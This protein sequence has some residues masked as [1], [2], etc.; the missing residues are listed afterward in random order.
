ML[1][2]VIEHPLKL[3]MIGTEAPHMTQIGGG[4]GV[5]NHSH[6]ESFIA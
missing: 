3:E 4:G 2:G 1:S 5:F 6:Q